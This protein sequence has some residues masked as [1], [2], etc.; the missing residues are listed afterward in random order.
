VKVC[1]KLFEASLRGQVFD[2][3]LAE[4]R[5]VSRLTMGYGPTVSLFA[6][7]FGKLWHDGENCPYQQQRRNKWS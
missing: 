7:D 4:G 1:W 6:I 3:E 5:G 2:A